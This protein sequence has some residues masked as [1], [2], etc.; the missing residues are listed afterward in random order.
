MPYTLADLDAIYRDPTQ[1]PKPTPP[2]ASEAQEAAT[3]NSLE[4]DLNALQETLD[5]DMMEMETGHIGILPPPP[6]VIEDESL[7]LQEIMVDNV[8]ASE[9]VLEDDVFDRAEL[10]DD[11][12]QDTLKDDFD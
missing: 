12:P 1:E 2:P 6:Q 3:E 7:E 9:V 8:V 11:D 10:L 5:K 4:Q